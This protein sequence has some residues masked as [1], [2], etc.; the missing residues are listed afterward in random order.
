MLPPE[1]AGS[2]SD[3]TAAPLATD[4]SLDFFALGGDANRDRIVDAADLGIVSSN[5]QK[6]NQV[7]SQGDFNYDRKVEIKD[8]LILSTN[9]QKSL[10]PPVTTVS[11]GRAAPTRTPTRV[12]SLL[13]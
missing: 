10:P 6:T 5:W 4:N 8:L 9:W 7:F 12:I 1:N 2:L 13:S 3:T 11:L